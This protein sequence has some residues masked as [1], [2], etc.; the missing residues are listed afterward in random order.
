MASVKSQSLKCKD[1]HDY[2][3]TLSAAT[4]E[5]LYAHPATCLAVFRELPTIAKHYVMRLL[6]VEQAV[7]QAVISS[8]L[9]QQHI[10]K[11]A[12]ALDTIC[13]LHIWNDF[14]VP[15]GL[16]GWILSPTFRKN[17]KTALLGG[18]VPWL[19]CA[20]LPKDKHTKDVA[21]LDSYAMERW[22]SLLNYMV[23]SHNTPDSISKETVKVLQHSGLMN[24]AN[25]V[26][27]TI[28]TEGFQFL[29]M[30]TSAQV[31]YF[32]L[33]YLDSV[34]SRGL[35]LVDCLTFLFQ[36]S[37]LTLG[38]DYS[39]EEMGEAMLTF[40]QH[41]RE[42]GLVYQRKRTCGRF[43]PTRLAINLASGL[44]ES[45]LDMHHPGFIAVETTFRVY[46]YTESHLQ[47]ALIGLFCEIMGRYPGFTVGII[48]RDSVRQALRTGITADQIIKFLKMHVHSQ[49]L[50]RQHAIPPTVVD[51]IR[52]WEL[53]RDRFQFT[54]GVLYS[55]FLSQSDFELLSNYAS[56]LGV[57]VWSN[58]SKRVMVVSKSGHDDVKRFWKRHR[59][60]H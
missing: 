19:V 8:W 18:S 35:N 39:T 57:L 37:F 36:I 7:P 25:D 24:S 12:E 40:L 31:W 9:G 21:F 16:P 6:F 28:T 15:G 49:R 23:G 14:P 17:I 27:Y 44:K 47:I 33:Q 48:T 52:L 56:D 11:H 20:P 46:A 51:Q 45:S 34:E 3:K 41:L 43:Y 50:K 4:L 54:E 58:P 55:Q 53:E 1:L 38:K 29:L 42:L 60:D 26:N 32:M 59:Q 2:L 13:A 22:E 10:K 5:K 30:N